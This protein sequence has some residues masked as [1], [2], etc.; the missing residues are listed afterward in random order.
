MEIK[1]KKK[2]IYRELRLLIS[3]FST[4]TI[5]GFYTLLNTDNYKLLFLEDFSLGLL[6]VFS[7]ITIAIWALIYYSSVN[8]ELR[9]LEDNFSVIRIRRYFL[10]SYVIAFILVISLILAICNTYNILI[11]SI[12]LISV[13]IFDIWANTIVTILIFKEFLAEKVYVK[14]NKLLKYRK[15]ITRYYLERPLFLILSFCLSA[16]FCSLIFSLIYINNKNMLYGK[17]A[18]LII[19]ITMI[20]NLIIFHFWRKKRDDDLNKL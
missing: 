15:R 12:F 14:K 2:N 8:H 9:L 5:G 20:S 18:Y 16:Y 11:C 7:G 6:S 1:K 17:V 19:I 3:L 13:G 4:I 10:G